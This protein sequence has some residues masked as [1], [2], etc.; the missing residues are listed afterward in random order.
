MSRDF[1]TTEAYNFTVSSA[2]CRGNAKNCNFPNELIIK[3]LEGFTRVCQQDHVLGVFKNHYRSVKNFIN[4]DA[5]GMDCDNDHSDDPDDWKTPEDVHKAFKDVPFYV[6]YSRNHMKDKKGKSA[7]PRF[8]I[9][10]PIDEMTDSTAYAALK[11]QVYTVFPFF[12]GNALD[13]ARLFFGT[14]NPKVEFYGGSVSLNTYLQ[15]QENHQAPEAPSPRGDK[16]IPEGERNATLHR[17]AVKIIKRYGESATAWEQFLDEA[18]KC[19]PPLEDL[20]VDTIWNSAAKFFHVTIETQEDYL[21]PEEYAGDVRYE[22]ADHT[23][24]G[25]A[26]VLK[27]IFGDTVRFTTGTGYLRYNGVIWEESKQRAQAAAQ[28]LTALQLKE[29]GRELMFAIRGLQQC[30]ADRLLTAHSAK[31]AEKEFNEEQAEAYSLYK[32]ARS[33]HMF[34]MNRRESKNITATL[35]E[36]QPML[37]M[38]PAEL[39]T[40]AYLLNTPDYTIDLRKGMKGIQEHRAEDFITKCTICS[41]SNDGM[42]QWLDSLKLFFQDDPELEKYV[43]EI[44]GLAAIGS[45]YVE[46]MIMAHG[47][48]RNGKSTFWNTISAVLGSYSGK[49]SADTLTVGCRRNVKPELAETKGKRLLIAS[50]LEEGTRL[51][52]ATIKQFCS[53][54]EIFA[55]KKYKDPFTFTPSHTL[56]L[57]T[58]HLPKVGAN[59]PGTWRRLVVVPFN[60]TIEGNKDILNYSQHLIETCGGA[61]LAWIIEGAKNIIKKNFKLTQP[62]C[63]VKAIDAYR[64]DND[65]LGHFLEERCEVGKDLLQ[66][67]GELYTA[68]RS[69]CGIKGEYTRSTSDFY[70][71]LDLAGFNKKRTKKGRFV[72]GLKLRPYEPEAVE[73]FFI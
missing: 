71:A 3:A 49:L 34:V 67:S 44:V 24:V 10:F 14:A 19:D 46:F 17:I 59:D 27:R 22:P 55:E 36:S 48:G 13:A 70:A 4:A 32:S 29:A 7:R 18:G 11:K 12:D 66:K 62:A 40:D 38:N 45:V 43:Q 69:Y 16:M 33:Y 73:D 28:E 41:P 58:N 52:T 68:Y 1:K 25:Q 54:D 57:Y 2:E 21:P 39:D 42:K 47:G 6:C 15:V 35:R 5:L 30:G 37:E 9:I 23:D 56:V 61:V 53:T 26:E 63:V 64:E 31:K 60:A 20:E 8:H 65:W 72:R 51:N 50:E